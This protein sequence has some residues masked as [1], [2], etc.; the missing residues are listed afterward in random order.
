MV[1][2]VKDDAEG[3][4]D[5][6]VGDLD[7]A[8]VRGDE[9]ADVPDATLLDEL[10]EVG[11][12]LGLDERPEQKSQHLAK[13]PGKEEGAFGAIYGPGWRITLTVWS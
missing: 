8:L 6:A 13:R 5:D 10:G 7:G 1:R 4:V 2:F 11:R 9:N 3:I 12:V